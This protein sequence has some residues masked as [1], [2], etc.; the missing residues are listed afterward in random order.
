MARESDF[1][2]RAYGKTSTEFIEIL[3]MPDEFI[4]FRDFFDANGL[5]NKWRLQYLALSEE[6]K[7]M[8]LQI[9]SSCND[10]NEITS[11]T[12]SNLKINTILSFYKIRKKDIEKQNKY[13]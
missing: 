1:F 12:S 8:L 3:S 11:T 4:R 13:L 9:L 7:K 5:S 2:V 10:I 6:E